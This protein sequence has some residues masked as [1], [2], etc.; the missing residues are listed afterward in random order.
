MI[1]FFFFFFFYRLEN[2][3]VVSSSVTVATIRNNTMATADA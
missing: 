3:W 2:L 1:F